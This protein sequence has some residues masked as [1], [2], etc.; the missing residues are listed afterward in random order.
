MYLQKSF[1]LE[2]QI[3]VVEM[4]VIFCYIISVQ[5]GGRGFES[6]ES[7]VTVIWNKICPNFEKLWLH[8]TRGW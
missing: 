6:Q 5:S 2:L 8:Y 3:C 1:I 4:F 7:L